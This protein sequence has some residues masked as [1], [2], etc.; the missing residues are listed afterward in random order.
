MG[1]LR[2]V[3]VWAQPAYPDEDWKTMELPTVW[4]SEG[5]SELDGVVWFRKEIFLEK[6]EVQKGITLHLG[7]IDDTDSTYVNGKFVGSMT[8]AYNKKRVYRVASSF[9]KAGRNVLT[10]WV[11]DVGGNGGIYGNKNSFYYQS[12]K[13]KT[14]LSDSW[15]FKVGKV[16]LDK[17]KAPNKIPTMLFNGMIHPIKDFPVKGVLWYQGEE[18][19]NRKE[20]ESYANWFQKMIKL[21]REKWNQGLPFLLVQLASYQSKT[22]DPN[23]PSNWAMLRES[24]SKALE[25]P[26][27]GQAIT[28]DIGDTWDIHPKNKQDVGLR[29]SLIARNLVYGE[30]IEYSGPVYKSMKIEGDKIR[31]QFDHF[32]SGLTTKDGGEYLKSFAIAGKDRKFVWAKAKIIGNEVIVWSEKIANPK[33]VRYA[34]A[35]NPDQINFYN[36]EGLPAVPFRTDNW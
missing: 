10:I 32:G 7:T 21:W 17:I 18:N 25:L 30:K 34:W 12:A 26:K 16:Y 31:L 20:A 27:T 23:R 3:P 35:N 36:K 15:K 28:I 33:A 4:E 13:G 24:Q 6:D 9:L 1:K 2:N 19:A 22:D 5:F 14:S 29:L 11:N 8:M